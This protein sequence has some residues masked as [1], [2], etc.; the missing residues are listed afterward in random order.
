MF[1]STHL[2]SA[3]LLVDIV[4]QYRDDTAPIDRALEEI[5]AVDA[6]SAAGRTVAIVDALVQRLVH[7]TEQADFVSQP[8]N[9][10]VPDGS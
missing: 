7:A 6:T 8:V 9:A 1:A 5:A 3:S 4:S 2:V 10:D